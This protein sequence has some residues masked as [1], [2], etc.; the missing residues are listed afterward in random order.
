MAQISISDR[1]LSVTLDWWEK[2][3]ARR[4]HFVIPLRVISSVDVVDNA[5]EA[6]RQVRGEGERRQ[7]ATRIPG[8]TTT[9]TFAAVDGSERKT[10]VVCHREGPGIVLDLTGATVDRII[11]STP[12]AEYYA[13]ELAGRL[14]S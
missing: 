1:R 10:F 8:V 6:S 7:S 9:G 3:V 11:I 5:Q 4:S 12:H 2:I 14:T 13:A